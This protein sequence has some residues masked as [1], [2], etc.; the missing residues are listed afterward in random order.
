MQPK[1]E[2]RLLNPDTGPSPHSSLQQFLLEA[3]VE[4]WVTPEMIVH[5]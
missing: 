3:L 2:H 4:G 5:I 1:S